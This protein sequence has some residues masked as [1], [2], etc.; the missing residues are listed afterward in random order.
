MKLDF[1][2]WL[3]AN[4]QINK[5]LLA[6][7]VG[8]DSQNQAPGRADLRPW[9]VP[10]TVTNV[11]YDTQ[12]KSLYRMG[13]AT[14][15]DTLYWLSWSTVVHAIRGF[16]A[17]DLQERTYFSGA[18]GGPAWTD[19][20]MALPSTPYPTSSRPLGVPGPTAAPIL[21]IDT[22]GSST[23]QEVRT[24]VT[25][26]VNDLG[27]ES[28]P[29][30]PATI[31]CNTDALITVSNM[32]AAPSG[33]YGINRRRIYRTQTGSTSA[34]FFL[35]YDLSSADLVYTG[36]AQSWTESTAAVSSYDPLETQT[37]LGGWLPCPSD[38][39]CLTQLWNMMAAVITGKSLRFCVAG[40]IYAWPYDYELVIAD[41]PIALGV[42]GQNLLVL[43]AGRFPSL[44]TGQDPA[45]MSEQPINDFP[46]NGACQSVTSVISFP[47]GVAWA[48]PDG[49]C[50]LGA[51]GS[52]VITSGLIHPA[53]WQALGPSTM[54]CSQFYGM[55]VVFYYDT[56]A[57]AWKGFMVDPINPTGI[58]W[59][60]QG[61]QAVY[62]DPLTSSMFVLD[63]MG[64]IQKWDAGASFMTATFTSRAVRTASANM[65]FARVLA[66][67]YPVTLSVIA[68]GVTRATRSITSDDVFSLPG[69]Y[70]AQVWQVHVETTGAPITSA[71]IAETDVELLP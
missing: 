12:R 27:W 37:T 69:G 13:R 25:T 61:Y 11:P 64:H 41:Q 44:I 52:R 56:A 4:T 50:Y 32:E 59:L 3:G 34:E 39:T 47:H 5:M 71:H 28:A 43:T 65:G 66:D 55:A 6:E 22:A 33:N 26:F 60:S 14:A 51:S 8:T 63:T 9:H 57:T 46:F 45:S 31:T 30:P 38:A 17:E 24:Y 18:A 53:D 16:D 10:S 1:A 7:G 42:W 20:T 62:A 15:S 48:G 67:S 19:N 58:Y 49:L 29:S 36:G 54:V 40:T 2:G 68:D 23:D 35:E 70:E 21:A